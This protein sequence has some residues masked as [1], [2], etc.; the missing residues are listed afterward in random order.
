LREPFIT[1]ISQFVHKA[2]VGGQH[3]VILD[4]VELVGLSHHLI[5][6]HAVKAHIAVS[7]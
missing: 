7:A 4:V 2:D 3:Q 5:A 1:S 6:R